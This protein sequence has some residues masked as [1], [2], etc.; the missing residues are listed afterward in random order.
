MLPKLKNKRIEKGLTTTY[1]SKQLNVTLQTYR[2]YESGTRNPL[3]ETTI[4][5]SEILECK[6]DELI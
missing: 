2:A 4:K 5:I 3:L 1:M 6:V